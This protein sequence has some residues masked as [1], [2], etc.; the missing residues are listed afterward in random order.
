MTYI[1]CHGATV[2]QMSIAKPRSA[3]RQLPC[4]A[5]VHKTRAYLRLN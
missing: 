1:S 2:S 4:F 3:V 5:N